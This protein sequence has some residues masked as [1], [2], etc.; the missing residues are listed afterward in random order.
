MTRVVLSQS[1][2]KEI[3]VTGSANMASKV[4]TAEETQCLS[5]LGGR[6]IVFIIHYSQLFTNPNP[7]TCTCTGLAVHRHRVNSPF[8]IYTVQNLRTFPDSY[9]N[10]NF[11]FLFSVCLETFSI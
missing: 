1:A 4:R 11:F 10:L 7:A 6:I 2:K 8:N 9:Y 5:W 3:G